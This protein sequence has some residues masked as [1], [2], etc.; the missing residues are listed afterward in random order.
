MGYR[1]TKKNRDT[2]SAYRKKR[3]KKS[4]PEPFPK[5]KSGGRQRQ[6]IFVIQKHA[7]SRLHYDF[8][9][10]V[11]GVLKSW[12]VPKGP[13]T[14]PR[15][16]RLAVM[17]EDHPRE[18]ASFEGVIPE[19]EYGAGTVL[20]WD[21]G[22]YRNIKQGDDGNAIPMKRAFADGHVEIWLDGEKLQGGYALTRIAKDNKERWLLAK[23]K[24]KK[25]DGRR[26]PTST[27]PKSVASGR[28]MKA[29]HKEEKRGANKE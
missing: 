16:R 22:T 6:P 27:Q 28:T 13:S 12:S 26:K 23:M 15:Q 8:R 9:L 3:N 14:D 20:I 5:K 2:L 11:D 1:V 24:D 17:T 18:Y 29:V 7:A 19:G 4:T 25:A 10:E 21:R